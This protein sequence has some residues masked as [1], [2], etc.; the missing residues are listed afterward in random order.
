MKI[1]FFGCSFTEGGGLNS[2]IWNK[3]AIKHNLIPKEFEGQYEKVKKHY[4]FSTLIGNEL[5][6]EVENFAVG[7]SSNETILNKLFENYEKF[8]INIVQFSLFN[9]LRIYDENTKSFY[10]VNGLEANAPKNTIDYFTKT[11]TEYQSQDYERY[12]IKQMVELYDKLFENLNKRIIWL[13]HEAVPKNLNSKNMIYFE[14]YGNI[15]D[16]V[17]EQEC[18][19]VQET[20]GY[21]DDSHYTPRGHEL[22]SKKILEKINEK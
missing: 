16:F 4:R 9:R 21:Y 8:D 14:P 20:K 18:T 10:D 6:C 3:Y 13:F 17:I 15:H 7:G 11:V 5:N 12:K 2:P 1:G 19:F 22:I